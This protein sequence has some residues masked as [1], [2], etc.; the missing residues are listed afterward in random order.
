M[1]MDREGVRVALADLR[2]RRGVTQAELARRM[3]K[4]VSYVSYLERGGRSN[5]TLEA[6]ES[7]ATAL[8]VSVQYVIT[9]A[10]VQLP[11]DEESRAL[12]ADLVQ[13]LPKLA[14]EQKQILRAMLASWQTL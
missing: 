8:G 4:S 13:A 9:G 7:W 1:G 14:D 3:G 11:D 6:L 10:D 5:P 2:Q 12:M